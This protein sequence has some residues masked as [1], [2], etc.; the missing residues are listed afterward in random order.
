V[1]TIFGRKCHY[2]RVTASNPSERAFN[3]RPPT[4]LMGIWY[5]TVD[6][7]GGLDEVRAIPFD[8]AKI[9]RPHHMVSGPERLLPVFRF[10]TNLP[11]MKTRE[12]SKVRI[13]SLITGPEYPFSTQSETFLIVSL[14]ER[15]INTM[16]PAIAATETSERL[17]PAGPVFSF[18][19]PSAKTRAPRNVET[20]LIIR[21]PLTPSAC[22]GASEIV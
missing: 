19:N 6:G 21:N 11:A 18:E 4:A 2:P 22:T 10:H 12:L 1:T 13:P 20:K 5:R 9:V 8:A 15:S 3:R 16:P 14:A 7:A 17:F